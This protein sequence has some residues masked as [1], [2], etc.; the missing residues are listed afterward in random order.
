MRPAI[1]ASADAIPSA[2]SSFNPSPSEKVFGRE[3]HELKLLR[4]VP[5]HS[6]TVG[7]SRAG[8][9]WTPPVP[10]SF[11]ASPVAQPDVS[12][13]V[14]GAGGERGG[15]VRLIEHVVG[16][17]LDEGTG[18]GNHHLVHLPWPAAVQAFDDVG[19]PSSSLRTHSTGQASTADDRSQRMWTVSSLSPS[20]AI[21]PRS[22]GFGQR[23]T[24]REGPRNS[25]DSPTPTSVLS[26]RVG[27]LLELQRVPSSTDPGRTTGKRP[28]AGGSTPPPLGRDRSVEDPRSGIG[29]D[30]RD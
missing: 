23:I 14:P 28:R 6:G 2:P 25:T 4:P 9:G 11:P 10:A 19:H 21:T 12:R 15:A 29:R 3:G 16:R 26:A 5:I 13:P 17:Q 22:E 18:S 27:H 8:T 24:G 1:A 7:D 30:A 20:S